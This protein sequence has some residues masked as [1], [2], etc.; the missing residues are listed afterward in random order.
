MKM[1]EKEANHKSEVK[2]LVEIVMAKTSHGLH[3]CEA[4]NAI[5]IDRRRNIHKNHRNNIIIEPTL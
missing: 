4:E 2:I 1:L 5:K 3:N